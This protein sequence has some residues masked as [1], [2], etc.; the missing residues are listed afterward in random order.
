MGLRCK[1]GGAVRVVRPTLRQT[2]AEGRSLPDRNNGRLHVVPCRL[3]NFD[4]PDGSGG[5]MGRVLGVPGEPGLWI[6]SRRT[7]RAR[8]C[9]LRELP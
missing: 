7:G 4:V 1:S 5:R 2:L 3:Q 6:G 9:I 8:V